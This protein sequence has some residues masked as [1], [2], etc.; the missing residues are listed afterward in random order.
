MVAGP[1]C[2]G[3]ALWEGGGGRWL[4]RPDGLQKL[5]EPAGGGV[6]HKVDGAHA[7]AVGCGVVR[8]MACD[9]VVSAAQVEHMAHDI[10]VVRRA[11]GDDSGGGADEQGSLR[12]GRA[13]RDCSSIYDSCA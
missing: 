4:Q 6:P 11:C 1:A 5:P 8:L 2:V 13:E 3:R 12:C 7:S 10:G 9:I